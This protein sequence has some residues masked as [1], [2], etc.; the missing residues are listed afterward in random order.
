[1]NIKSGRRQFSVRSLM[2]VAAVLIAALW[3]G[4]PRLRSEHG[5]NA[6]AKNS[7]GAVPV[8]AAL[9]E[10]RTIPIRLS[11]VGNVE[12][13]TAV[14]VKSRVDGQIIRVLFREGDRVAKGAPLFELD[15]RPFIAGV[16]QAEAALERDRAQLANATSQRNR[17]EDLL[18]KHFVSDEAFNQ[19]RTNFDSAVAVVH[20]DEANLDNLRLQLEFAT[21][22]SPI[23]GVAGRVLI[24]EGNLVKAN[25]VNPLVT[26]NQVSPIYV[27]FSAPEQQLASI[28]QVM[29]SA[30]QKVLAT[31][32]GTNDAA[33]GKLTFIDNAVDSTTGS[34]KLKAVFPNADRK[35]WPGQFVNVSLLLGQQ[36]DATVVPAT[37]VQNGPEGQIAFVVHDDQTVEV[38]KVTLQRNTGDLAVVA[39]GLAPGEKVVTEGQLRL[40]D[41]SKVAIAQDKAP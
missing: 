12:A 18:R 29:G 40:A 6:A 21:I 5:A 8:K 35:L 30:T 20:A 39:S 41:K 7:G 4:L 10:K 3:F 28:R 37:A 9:V 34:I 25:D 26:L 23:D 19:I 16:K 2:I 32:P 31:V 1:M 22:R 15:P 13:F 11:A 27:A 38:R 33:E 36:A 14:A 24:Q 17:Y